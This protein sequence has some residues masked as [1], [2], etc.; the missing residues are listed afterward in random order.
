MIYRTFTTNF[1][2]STRDC[3][4][5]KLQE[6]KKNSWIIALECQKEK[7]ENLENLQN[8][9]KTTMETYSKTSKQIT[10]NQQNIQWN[11]E[12]MKKK[13][14]KTCKCRCKKKKLGN[15]A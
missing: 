11:Q 15:R 9:A 12:H 4:D 10:K 5:S 7:T 13:S 2:V 6:E 8:K 1:F 3:E 14:R